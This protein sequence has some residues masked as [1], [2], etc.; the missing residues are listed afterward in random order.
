MSQ[1]WPGLLNR[2]GQLDGAMWPDCCGKPRRRDITH[3][4]IPSTA[5]AEKAEIGD[6]LYAR[7]LSI[8]PTKNA[9]WPAIFG[10][11][12]IYFSFGLAAGRQQ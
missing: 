3:F 12:D 2:A 4:A 11:V 8:S 10:V 7:P 6:I 1:A 9:Y 5:T